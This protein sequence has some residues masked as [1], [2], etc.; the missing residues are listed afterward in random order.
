M[1]TQLDW[2]RFNYNNVHTL[3]FKDADYLVF[4]PKKQI[5]TFHL[6]TL[7]IGSTYH[8]LMRYLLT[9]IYLNPDETEEVCK[10]V[11][12]ALHINC[13]NKISDTKIQEIF[14]EAIL[15]MNHPDLESTV[16][17]A[18]KPQQ[19]C[20]KGYVINPEVAEEKMHGVKGI[21]RGEYRRT[22]TKGRIQNVL[23]NW[24]PYWGK[25]T[26][27]II[28]KRARLTLKQVST[29][30]PLL[31]SERKKASLIQKPKPMNK[32]FKML[33]NTLLN[34]DLSNGVPTNKDLV[35]STGLGLSTIE[36]YSPK[37][38]MLKKKMRAVIKDKNDKRT[39]I[40]SEFA[41]FDH[42][43]YVNQES[44][45]EDELQNEMLIGSQSELAV[46]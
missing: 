32:T 43:C 29:Y 15:L 33:W 41:P 10:E 31:K 40:I 38:K 20:Y 6:P 3:D 35:K 7:I 25:P 23:E 5:I 9:F 37:L 14:D 18:Y 46:A 36:V 24:N 28:A 13:Q 2:S 8:Q 44:D 34:W 1:S 39:K 17:L 19:T 12:I 42:K 26:N 4:Y 21:A 22:K 30:M 11:L 27:K 45:V 16:L